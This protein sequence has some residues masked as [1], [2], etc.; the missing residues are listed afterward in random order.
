MSL[1]NSA[2]DATSSATNQN[3]QGGQAAVGAGAES[4]TALS[5]S[6]GASQYGGDIGIVMQSPE[7]IE[8]AKLVTE[9]ALDSITTIAGDAL[10]LSS[11][12]AGG[13]LADVRNKS[14]NTTQTLASVAVPVA[15]VVV[16]GLG[17]LLYFRR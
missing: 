1:G 4:S 7:T 3:V 13:A 5:I 2:S 14:E 6:T 9:R 8:A 16:L 15:V 17:L 12:L 11:Q 10:G